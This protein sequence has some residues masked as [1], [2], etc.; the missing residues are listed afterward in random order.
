MPDYL[1]FPTTLSELEEDDAAR[2]LQ[3]QKERLDEAMKRWSE[4][5]KVSNELLDEVVSV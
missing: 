5:E 3:E 2:R 1:D 4:S